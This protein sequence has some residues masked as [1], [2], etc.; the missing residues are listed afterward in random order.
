MVDLYTEIFSRNIGFLTESEQDMLRHAT[1]GIA[2]VGGVGGLLA[3]RLIRLGVG[4]IKIIDPGDFEHS[5]INRQYGSAIDTMGLNKAEVVFTQLRDINPQARIIW[6]GDGIKTQK[7]AD[8]FVADC[9]VVIDETDFGLFREAIFLQRAARQKGIYYM[10]TSAIGFGAL[11]AIFDPHGLTLEEYNGIDP[12]DDLENIE[13]EDIPL[14][15]ICPVVPSYAAS[16]PPELMNDIIGGKRGLPTTS[17]G[18]GLASILAANEAVNIL[19]N[20]RDVASAPQYTYVDLMD[21]KL[22]VGTV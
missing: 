4:C 11:I 6:S 1:A 22:I 8:L 19:L 14:D 17:I 2:G 16:M 18:V 12:D 15:K 21:R 13:K 5:N 10:F 20:K 3:E 7:D 9:D